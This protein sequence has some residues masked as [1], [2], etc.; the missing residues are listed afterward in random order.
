MIVVVVFVV[1]LLAMINRFLRRER[2][3]SPA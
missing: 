2:L 1:L 3:L